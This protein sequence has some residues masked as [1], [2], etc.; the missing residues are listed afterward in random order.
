MYNIELIILLTYLHNFFFL[1]IQ[2]SSL[3]PTKNLWIYHSYIFLHQYSLSNKTLP[4]SPN[5]LFIHFELISKSC[6]YS[7]RIIKKNLLSLAH[8]Y[9]HWLSQII[10]YSL[11]IQVI[12]FSY[13]DQP[14]S[15]QSSVYIR[16]ISLHYVSYL[17]PPLLIFFTYSHNLQNTF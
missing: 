16:V 15:L 17:S 4:D 12:L 11:W 5:L 7:F 14:N 9:W 8:H 2:I 10:H 3:F 13:L 1:F 6:N